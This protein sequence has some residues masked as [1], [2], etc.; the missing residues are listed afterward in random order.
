MIKF[1]KQMDESWWVQC[2]EAF[3]VCIKTEFTILKSN[4]HSNSISP[5]QFECNIVMYTYMRA[6]FKILSPSERE[7]AV[8]LMMINDDQIGILSW[9]HYSTILWGINKLRLRMPRGLQNVRTQ[10]SLDR[11]LQ[12]LIPHY[13]TFNV[14][15][16][17]QWR[18]GLRLRQR[19]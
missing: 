8:R 16:R 2:R 3:V 7:H 12:P 4:L 17:Q 5:I 1:W 11:L 6:Q 9:C 14:W 13:Q 19:G 15:P 10:W 18:Q